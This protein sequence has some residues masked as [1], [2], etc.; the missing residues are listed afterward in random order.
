M[1]MASAPHNSHTARTRPRDAMIRS[2]SSKPEYDIATAIRTDTPT[3]RKS[4][5]PVS[6]VSSDVKYSMGDA[7]LRPIRQSGLVYFFYRHLPGEMLATRD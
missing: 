6:E 3:S 5:E 7:E 2:V 4:Y 1:P